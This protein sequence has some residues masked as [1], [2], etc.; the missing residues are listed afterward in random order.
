LRWGRGRFTVYNE[1]FLVFPAPV[2]VLTNHLLSLLAGRD[3][4]EGSVG[5]SPNYQLLVLTHRPVILERSEE[6]Q[7]GESLYPSIVIM[8]ARGEPVEP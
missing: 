4:R 7:G 3:K 8:N 6:Y 2:F 5:I 1:H